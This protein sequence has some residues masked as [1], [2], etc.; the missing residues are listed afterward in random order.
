VKGKTFTATVTEGMRE[1]GE[2][3]HWEW[4]KNRKISAER[5]GF[6]GEGE[7]SVSA[8]KVHLRGCAEPGFPPPWVRVRVFPGEG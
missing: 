5:G 4:G 6:W 1:G 8:G 3:L 2:L 7:N